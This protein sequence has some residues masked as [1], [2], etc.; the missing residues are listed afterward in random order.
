MSD[1]SQT[2]DHNKEDLAEV[3]CEGPKRDTWSSGYFISWQNERRHF[4]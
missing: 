1:L 4:G 3:A 2:T